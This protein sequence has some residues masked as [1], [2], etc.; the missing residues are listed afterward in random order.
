MS[1]LPSGHVFQQWTNLLYPNL[2]E[3]QMYEEVASA[4]AGEQG[5]K[6]VLSNDLR[7]GTLFN[8][9]F[10]ANRGV[11][12]RAVLEGLAFHSCEITEIL[13]KYAGVSCKGITVTGHPTRSEF[14][15]NLRSGVSGKPLHIVEEKETA[16][17]GAALLAMKKGTSFLT[18][19]LW[20]VPSNDFYKKLLDLY[21]DKGC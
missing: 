18:R 2:D 6:F 19:S 1:S 13:T 17:L 20:E 11:V 4:S 16:A 14:W 7:S 9:P 8:L 15:K 12:L 10:E 5:V 21:R 3:S